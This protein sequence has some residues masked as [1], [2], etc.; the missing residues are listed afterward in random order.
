MVAIQNIL[1]PEQ[2]PVGMSL[3]VFSQTFGGSLFLTFAQTIFGHSLISGLKKYAPAVDPQTVI[4]AGV[5]SIRE[6]V[7]PEEIVGVVEAYNLAINHNFYLAAGASVGTFVFAWG[8][9]W[10]SIKKKKTVT[11]EA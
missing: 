5:T 2:N 6:A 4:T 3:V 1:P 7:K 9:G 10:Y 8:M 11:P